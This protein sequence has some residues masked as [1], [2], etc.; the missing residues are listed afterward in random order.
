LGF[1]QD[2]SN[3]HLA[4]HLTANPFAFQHPHTHTHPSKCVCVC[5]CC[6]QQP[7][8]WNQT[9]NSNRVTQRAHWNYY[10]CCLALPSPPFICLHIWI[11]VCVCVCVF[12]SCH[13]Q[14]I[15]TKLIGTGTGEPQ[16]VELG[17]NK[18]CCKSCESV[19]KYQTNSGCC[20]CCCSQLHNKH[21]HTHLWI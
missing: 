12:V 4:I 9:C 16:L 11:C 13:S 17:E 21:T 15:V 8:N 19:S 2:T 7:F 18:H 5:V 6:T 1:G 14:R 20:C 10:K 3:Q